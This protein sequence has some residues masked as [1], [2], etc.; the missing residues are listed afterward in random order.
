MNRATFLIDGFNLY[1]SARDA[2]KVLNSSTKWLDIKKLCSS[3]LPI[4]SGAVKEKTRIEKVY[5]FSAFAKHIEVYDPDVTTRHKDLIKCFED[6]GVTVEIS[7]FKEKKIRCHAQHGCRK[8]FV[9]HEEKETD[10]A[11]AAKL[12]EVFIADECDTAVLVTGDTDIAPAVTTANRLFPKK[13]IL[14]AFPYKRKNKELSKLFPVSF[15]IN[16]KQYAKNQFSDPYTLSDGTLI[17]KPPS[18]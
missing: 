11:I 2:E 5:Y 6:T 4:V 9:K 12:F 16:I 18:W 10:V 1:H 15:K 7:R 17:N 3:Y 14:F 13:T 8:E